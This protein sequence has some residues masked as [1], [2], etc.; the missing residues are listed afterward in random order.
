MAIARALTIAGAAAQ[1]SA[2][3][4][5]DLKTFQERNVYGMCT[6]TAIVANNPVTERGI[7]LHPVEQIKAQF[8]TSL[9]NVGIDAAKTGML[10]SKD[11]IELV[12]SLLK[13]HPI[14]N[15]VVDPVMI[16]KMGSQLLADEAIEIVK[17]ELIPLATIITPNKYEAAR[18]LNVETIETIA[19]LKQAAV[20]LYKLGCQAVL[21]KGGPMSE[22]A[23]DIFYDGN[24]IVELNSSKV[25]TIHTSGAGCTYSAVI[26]AELAKGTPLR[27]SVYI[28]KEFVYEAIK[29]AISF[30]NGIGS[31]NHGG[32]RNR[33]Y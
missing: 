18:L 9:T 19:E 3:I 12:V 20:E 29:S 15:L 28:G 2:G 17:S 30:D 13:E 24:E 22:T 31:V 32:H 10:F 8:Y 6:I 14:Q 4:Q 23:T 11:I 25:D 5:A 26:T 7:F 16:G 33:I 27:E 21:I 1:G